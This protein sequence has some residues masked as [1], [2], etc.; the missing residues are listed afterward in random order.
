MGE[1]TPIGDPPPR[2]EV[3]SWPSLLLPKKYFS[4]YQ[5]QTTQTQLRKDLRK[6]DHLSSAEVKSRSR[7]RQE[8]YCFLIRK[9]D[10]G[11][12]VLGLCQSASGKKMPSGK[13]F[14]AAFQLVCETLIEKEKTLMWP[15]NWL[16][17]KVGT[18]AAGVWLCWK[19]DLG[20][21][22]RLHKHSHE[23]TKVETAHAIAPRKG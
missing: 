12:P 7:R 11:F 16:T 21:C 9:W 14:L 1:G 6:E 8:R 18:L 23:E 17:W 20:V 22:Q 4:G 19:C 10:W 5:E 3:C 2:G 15:E 13:P